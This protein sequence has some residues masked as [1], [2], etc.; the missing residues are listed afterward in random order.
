MRD[1]DDGEMMVTWSTYCRRTHEEVR[2][3]A[4]RH[5]QVALL[6]DNQYFRLQ[7][8]GA[9][10]SLKKDMYASIQFGPCTFQRL[11]LL[12]TSPLSGTL[13]YGRFP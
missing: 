1:V 8:S 7:K 2:V 5:A 11:S 6:V 4:T 3:T 13:A 12:C 10:A 9:A